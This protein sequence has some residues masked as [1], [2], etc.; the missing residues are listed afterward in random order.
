MVGRAISHYKI[1]ERLGEGG[2]WT[3]FPNLF[4]IN[5]FHHSV[6]N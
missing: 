6:L 5:N 4:E 1:L 3:C 2:V